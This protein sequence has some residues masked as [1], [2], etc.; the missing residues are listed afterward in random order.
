LRIT[1]EQ[2]GFLKQAI[3]V[4]LPDAAVFL[5]GSRVHDH[6]RGGDIDVLVIAGKKLTRQQTRELKIAFYKRFGEQKID[7]VC[8]HEA[9]DS[10]FKN[11]ALD[12]AVRL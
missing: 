7:I 11:L 12:E 1:T 2:S 6:L 4:I 5:F 10:A 9:D 3:N 8:F